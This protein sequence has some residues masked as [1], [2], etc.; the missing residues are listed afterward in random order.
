MVNSKQK[1]KRVELELVHWLQDHGIRAR[2]TQ[3]FN[4]AEG[5]SDI[6]SEDLPECHIEC[7]GTKDATLNR[8]TLLDWLEQVNRDCP[9]SLPV[10][11]LFCKS[12]NK[13]FVAATP[14]SIWEYIKPAAEPCYFAANVEAS[15]NPTQELK[16]VRDT[17]R[18]LYF[19]ERMKCVTLTGIYYGADLDNGLG[20]VFLDGEDWLHVINKWK[21]VKED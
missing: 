8:S 5:L 15:I 19:A 20:W 7:K 4:G 16:K 18:L 14:L 17:V 9:P 6:I 10:S 2:R 13:P 21:A 3:Q 12:N 11:V 1:G